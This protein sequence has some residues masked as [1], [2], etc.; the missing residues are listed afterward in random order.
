MTNI[1]VSLRKIKD[2]KYKNRKH[3][4]SWTIQ[5]VHVIFGASRIKIRKYI[6]IILNKHFN[7]QIYLLSNKHLKSK[8]CMPM[9]SLFI[10]YIMWPNIFLLLLLIYNLIL[11][12]SSNYV[13]WKWVISYI[14]FHNRRMSLLL[15]KIII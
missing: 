3:L 8:L 1:F 14:S 13:T 10:I 11:I 7:C 9:V 4:L 6:L 5:N 15:H 2:S 12:K